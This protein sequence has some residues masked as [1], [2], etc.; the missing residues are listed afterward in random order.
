[1]VVGKPFN[2][3]AEPFVVEALTAGHVDFASIANNHI[4]DFAEAGLLHTV[5]T[6]DRAGIA[7]AG[8]G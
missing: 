3:R 2:F 4:L 5:Q 8:A 1:M 6:L 7:H